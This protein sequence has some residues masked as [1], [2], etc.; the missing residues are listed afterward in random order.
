MQRS[1]IKRCFYLQ[2]L[3][4]PAD[5][6]HYASSLMKQMLLNTGK[7]IYLGLALYVLV[8]TL[9]HTDG[10]PEQHDY[11][12]AMVMAMAVLS[13]PISLLVILGW[14]VLSIVLTAVDSLF[15]RLSGL[16]AS[17]RIVQWSILKLFWLAF[18][19]AGYYQWF[20]LIPRWLRRR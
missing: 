12:Q 7:A 6:W 3:V 2:P 5:A 1:A 11:A 10:S 13:F 9:S 18:T 8:L 20:R 4:A 15:P 19:A 16:G 17:S 14:I